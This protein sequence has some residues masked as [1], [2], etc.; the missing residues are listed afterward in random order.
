MLNVEVNLES[1]RAGLRGLEGGARDLSPATRGIAG[2]L[3]DATE[4]AFADEADPTT[5]AYWLPLSPA[6]IARRAKAGKWPGKMLQVTQGGLAASVQAD[7]GPDH[8]RIGTDKVYA[9]AMQFGAIKGAF[10]RTKRGAPI[11]WGDIPGRP[12][13]GLGPGDEEE[14]FDLLRRH[15][16][17]AAGGAR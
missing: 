9:P 4:R 13:L 17:N 6:T 1:L 5:G 12:F 7:S 15:L 16:H 11:P 10:G 8:A 14:I 3:A 2:V